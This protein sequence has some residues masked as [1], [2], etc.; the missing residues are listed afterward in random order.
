SS[1]AATAKRYRYTGMERDKETG[2]AVHGARYYAGWLGRWGSA[3]PIGISGDKNVYRPFRNNPL[4]FVDTTGLAPENGAKGHDDVE[5]IPTSI[6]NRSPDFRTM[7][8]P[9]LPEI[10]GL[11]IIDGVGD[12]MGRF[13]SR[14]VK[15]SD[16]GDYY[17]PYDGNC[18][19]DA[20]E[21]VSKAIQ[22]RTAEGKNLQ[23]VGGMSPPRL[24]TFDDVPNDQST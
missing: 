8:A 9:G 6:R 3:D 7:E 20:S 18:Y 21:T 17:V 14:T 19:A 15:I 24:V 16:F 22:G 1:I 4:R 12:G 10:S 23:V 13:V 2:L 5:S 11:E